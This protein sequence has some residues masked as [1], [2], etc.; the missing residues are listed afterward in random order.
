MKKKSDKRPWGDFRQFTL[1]EKSTVKILTVKPK[2]AFSLQT[3]KNRREFWYFLEGS[4][5]IIAG[6]KKIKTFAEVGSSNIKRQYID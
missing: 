3:H 1:N 4:G 2:Q 5:T 6:E